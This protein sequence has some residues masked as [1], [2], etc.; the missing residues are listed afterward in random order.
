MELQDGTRKVFVN[1][2]GD[3]NRLDKK[4]RALFEYFMAEIVDDAFTA[5]LQNAISAAR[6]NQKW[7]V[8]YM[9]WLASEMDREIE[10]EE[11]KEEGRKEGIEAGRKEGIEEGRKE[12]IEAG[13]KEGIEE[14]RK[15]GIEVG[16]EAEKKHTALRMRG[17]G[18]DDE[19]I[20]AC[21]DITADLFRDWIA[22]NFD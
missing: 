7:E 2:K 19:Q 3:K 9:E 12:G 16:R 17:M 14:G 8:E 20:A 21:L 6:S 22:R 10:K 1:L 11:A 13:R 15:E 4:T 5:E 18:M